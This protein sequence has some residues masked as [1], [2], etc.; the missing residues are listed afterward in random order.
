MCVGR[1]SEATFKFLGYT[2]AEGEKITQSCRF[3]CDMCDTRDAVAGTKGVSKHYK[4]ESSP[5][6][7]VSTSISCGHDYTVYNRTSCEECSTAG[8]ASRRLA[9]D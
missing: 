8:S 2:K 5:H 3:T 6:A 9:E 7:V 1:C 4:G